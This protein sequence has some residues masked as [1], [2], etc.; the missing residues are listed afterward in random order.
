M[1]QLGCKATVP[2]LSLMAEKAGLLVSAVGRCVG[3][4]CVA[5]CQAHI[6]CKKVLPALIHGLS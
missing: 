1:C 2:A 3:W 5:P 6:H 4:V